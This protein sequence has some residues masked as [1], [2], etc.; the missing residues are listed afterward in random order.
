MCEDKYYLIQ[1]K[2]HNVFEGGSEGGL[3]RLE[4][5]N[6]MVV[7]RGIKSYLSIAQKKSN[8]KVKSG[9]QHSSSEAL[10]ATSPKEISK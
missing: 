8:S 3:G 9:R 2:V 1:K 7:Q 5:K 4:E 6:H 10:I